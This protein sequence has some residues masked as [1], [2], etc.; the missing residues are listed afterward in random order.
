[1]EFYDIALAKLLQTF[2]ELGN[3]I[4]TFQDVSDEINDSE[5]IHV[6]VFILQSG[7]EMFFIPIVSKA[8]N[9]YPIDSVFLDSK[10]K[11]FPLTK[12]TMNMIFEADRTNPGKGAKI[13][14]NTVRNPDMKDLINPPR[15]GKFVYA[16]TSRLKDFLSSLP[17]HL[18]EFTLDKLAS[19]ASLSKKLHDMYGF[20][21]IVESLRI[22]K[23]ASA[24]HETVYTGATVYFEKK[25]GLSDEAI[26]GILKQGY[27]IE[28]SHVTPR[29]ALSTF[30]YM[31]GKFKSIQRVDGSRD[32]EI[33]FRDGTTREAYIPRLLTPS[34]KNGYYESDKG[35][36][37]VALF[38]NG[39]YALIT[40]SLISVGEELPRN[41]VLETLFEFNPAI[42]PK[43]LNTDETFAVLSPVGDV[44][45]LFRADKVIQNHMGV[46]ITAYDQIG[47]GRVQIMAYRN[48]A[49]TYQY[50]RDGK[51]LYLPYASL[52]VV[53]GE[54]VS[55][56][57]LEVNAYAAADRAQITETSILGSHMKLAY[58]GVEYF[59]NGQ[60]MQ[61]EGHLLKS[62]IMDECIDPIKA[63]SFVKEAREN[64]QTT[65]YLTKK[66]DAF[67][68]GEIPQFGQQLPKQQDVG[69][70]GSFVPNVQAA[71]GLG[72]P[73]VAE[74]AIMSE[75]LQTPDM[76]ELIA[77]YLPDIE[78][79][80][81]KLGRI[82]FVS[83]VHIQKLSQNNDVDGVFSFLSSLKTVYKLLGDNLIKLQEL[84][85]V[86][87]NDQAEPE[88]NEK[89]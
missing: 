53:L 4:V 52:V 6:G 46:E 11:F 40:G 27:H 29:V 9:V 57:A 80:I 39:D 51:E 75:L 18:K 69:L 54:R 87:P 48:F 8:E 38:T 86:R 64:R 10:K 33:V 67:T 22:E 84:L 23:R 36:P 25:A 81:D 47:S 89:E 28:G 20:E 32:Y 59:V 45:G 1:M 2:P 17:D 62:L 74:V 85:A 35:G 21:S 30:D 65:I 56:S 70:N 71:A 88:G 31:D 26:Q 19:E 5:E 15:T 82:L 13:P 78:E 12:K 42:L 76:L 79:A 16:S 72:D 60:P 61:S 7:A 58:D 14:Q 55:S 66:A 41:T 63:Q 43:E 44:I 83:R 73:Q 68:P 50:E 3:F 49:G 24:P 37:V 34:I 77:E